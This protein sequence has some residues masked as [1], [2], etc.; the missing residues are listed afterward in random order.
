MA[1]T[2]HPNSVL[3]RLFN[4]PNSSKEKSDQASQTGQAGQANGLNQ[5]LQ[6]KYGVNASNAAKVPQ[7][8]SSISASMIRQ[9]EQAYGYSQTMSL[10]LTTKEGDKVSVDFRQL[11]AQYQSYKEAVAGQQ[12]PTGVRYFESREAMEMTA[13]EE[14]F[15][16]SVEGDLNEDELKAVF[17][18]FEQVDKLANQF[19]EGNIENALQEGMKM[20]LDFGQ[21][22]GMQLNMTQTQVMMNRQQQAVAAEY[23]QASGEAKSGATVAELPEYL[24]KW[25]QAID[26]LDQWFKDAQGAWNELMAGVTAQRFP[27]QD[28]SQGWFERVQEFHSQLLEMARARDNV[29]NDAVT[30]EPVASANTDGDLNLVESTQAAEKIVNAAEEEKK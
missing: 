14:R 30:E 20:E 29:M 13:F 28:S 26:S 1:S 15:A 5:A 16:F 3:D 6:N 2:I 24:Q 11:Y 19:Y 23:G 27:E 12:D 4:G 7:D 8:S 21:L 25:Q 18:V 17:D 9:A 22:Q 10:Q